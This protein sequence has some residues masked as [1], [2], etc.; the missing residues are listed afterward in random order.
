MICF[1]LCILM[2]CEWNKQP[3]RFLGGSLCTVQCAV[4]PDFIICRT[5][6]KGR[7]DGALSFE[8]YERCESFVCVLFSNRSPQ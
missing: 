1:A 6:S 5:H 8:A 3:V 7:P 4:Q 2:E